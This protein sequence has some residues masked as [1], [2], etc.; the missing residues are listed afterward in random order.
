[1]AVQIRLATHDDG[2]AVAE[3]YRPVVAATAFSFETILPDGNEMTRRIAE[4]LR[5]YPWLVCDVDGQ[6]AGYAYA[7]RH[8]VRGAYQWSVDTSVYIAEDHRRRHIGRGLYTSL[9]AILAAQGYFNAFAGIALPN[10]ASVALHQAMGFEPIGVY[11][12]V[13]YKLDRWH[14]VGWWQLIL[15]QHEGSPGV[16]LDIGTVAGRAGWSGL[17]TR[18]ES[19]IRAAAA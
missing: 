14:D 11:R 10:P 17:L 1:M 2:A 12:R 19:I 5:S 13:G 7:T 16:P 15:R 6:V 9:F 4:T 18:G 8:R 3:I